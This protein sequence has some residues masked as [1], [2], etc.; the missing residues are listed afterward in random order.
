MKKNKS[1]KRGKSFAYGGKA[2]VND[3]LQQLSKINNM[4]YEAQ[5]ETAMDPTVNLLKGLG[6]G[7]AN[8]GINMI[9][10]GLGKLAGAGG[11]SGFLGNNAKTITGGLNFLNSVNGM[12]ADGGNIIDNPD[13]EVEGQE[14]FETPMGETGMFQGPSHEEGGIPMNVGDFNQP[15]E[16]GEIPEGTFIYPKRLKVKGKSM[17]KRAEDR[18]KRLSKIEKLFGNSLHDNILKNSLNRTKTTN[19]VEDSVD[20][21]F[22]NLMKQLKQDNQ[23][24]EQF[25]L[26]G[27]TRFRDFLNL[28]KLLESN[29]FPYKGNKED[30]INPKT[31]T[32]S[33]SKKEPN[34]LN[35]VL[36]GEFGTL[37]DLIGIGGNLYQ[38]YQGI[39]DVVNQRKTDTPNIN[40]FKN[41][42]KEGLATLKNNLN[43]L[44][45]I[46]DNQL[47]KAQLSKNA[48][49]NRNRNNVRGLNTLR[50]LDLATDLG[51][52]NI[53]NDI[54]ANH[55]GQVM[56]ANNRIASSQF[57]IDNRV[58][59]GEQARDLAD[60]QDKDNYH[61]NLNRAR[62][63]WGEALS[64][65]GKNMNQI[66]SRNVNT[67]L[68]NQQFENVVF[69]SDGRIK[70]ADGIDIFNMGDNTDVQFDKYLRKQFSEKEIS[71]MTPEYIKNLKT[72]WLGGQLNPI[73]SNTNNKGS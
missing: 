48:T 56:D 45:E 42:G 33:T 15:L 57:D 71:Q 21:E 66:K 31:F 10:S 26:G 2:M 67:N 32:T 43:L 17:A 6:S 44:D 49:L 9:G 61:T 54:F 12:F 50:A 14:Y 58:M 18:D 60:R 4:G 5:V 63:N 70:T 59:A 37:G 25:S 1:Q 36:G 46:K 11:F 47:N 68:V 39:R 8:M 23:K 38:G 3:F 19:N 24:T 52:Q 13:I 51:Y 72:V 22:I 65:F 28:E 40:A 30:S 53:I 20:K 62:M 41:Y 69:G 35:K 64:R 73:N 29:V 16:E 55:A 27:D 7:L 34:I